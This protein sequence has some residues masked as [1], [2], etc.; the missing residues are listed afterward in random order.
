M[1]A[2]LIANDIDSAKKRDSWIQGT[3][4][5]YNNRAAKSI[6]RCPDEFIISESLLLLLLTAIEYRNWIS[7]GKLKIRRE[8]KLI[9]LTFE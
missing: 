5:T 2:P 6:N 9:S 3:F 1:L 4:V 7:A 8:T